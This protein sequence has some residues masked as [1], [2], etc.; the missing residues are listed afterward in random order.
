MGYHDDRFVHVKTVDQS[1]NSN[2]LLVY[3]GCPNRTLQTGGL[4]QQQFI[5]SQFWGLEV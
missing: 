3:S 4:K 2:S 5:F 1:M